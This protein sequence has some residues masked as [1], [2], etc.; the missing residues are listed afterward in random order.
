MDISDIKQY[1]LMKDYILMFENGRLALD[2]LIKDLYGLIQAL[3]A[4]E[5]EWKDTFQSEWWTLE[6]VYATAL[7]RGEKILNTES[8]DLVY[9][10]IENMKSLLK[11]I[12]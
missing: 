4:P 10:T 1:Q 5:E 11:Q 6:Q 3:Q 8:Q 2:E 12:E 7:D 9:E